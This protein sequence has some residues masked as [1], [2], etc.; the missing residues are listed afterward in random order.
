ML[1]LKVLPISDCP[2]S[3]PAERGRVT[4]RD[5]VCSASGGAPGLPL[6]RSTGAMSRPDGGSVLC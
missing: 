3:A 2:C 6:G 4:R 5:S 1:R